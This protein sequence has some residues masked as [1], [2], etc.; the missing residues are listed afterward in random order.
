[1]D[2]RSKITYIDDPTID[3]P[4]D[5]W[6]M[7]FDPRQR[8]EIMLALDYAQNYGHGT[9]GHMAYTV[10][11]RFATMVEKYAREREPQVLKALPE[12]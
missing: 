2:E 4:I 6:F 10:I 8:K 11:A 7:N 1:M 9:A 3:Q 12:S 5:D